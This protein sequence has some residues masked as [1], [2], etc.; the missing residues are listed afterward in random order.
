MAAGVTFLPAAQGS[1][2]R[3]RGA[4]RDGPDLFLSDTWREFDGDIADG[5]VR[6]AVMGLAAPDR[7][8][9]VDEEIRWQ[10]GHMTHDVRAALRHLPPLGADSAGPLGSGL[11]ARGLLASTIRTIQ[12]EIATKR[13]SQSP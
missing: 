12:A 8:D 7:P 1:Q 11:L 10:L 2:V 6:L 13:K 5:G 3:T 9:A 4:C